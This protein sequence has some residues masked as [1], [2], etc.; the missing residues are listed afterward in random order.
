MPCTLAER[1]LL[2]EAPSPFPPV[3]AHDWV[4]GPEDA[5]VT[6]IE[7]GDFQCPHCG[8][9]APELIRLR[10]E[11][12]EDVRLV[13][14]HFPL[15]SLHDKANLAAQAAEAAGAQGKFWQMHDALFLQ[16]EAWVNLSEAEFKD[17]LVA[18]A[19]ALALD[20]Q[21]FTAD[22]VSQSTVDVVRQA[23][24]A[25]LATGLDSTPSLVIDG[26][27]YEGAKDWWTLA[28]F[29]RLIQLESRHF[30]ACPPQQTA[31]RKQYIATLE[32]TKG[33]LTLELLSRQ[34]PLAVNNFVFLA[35][36][37]WYDGVE[38]YRVIPGYVT[39]TGDPSGT[40]LGGPGYTFADEINPELR[41]AAPGVVAMANSGPDSNG[42]QFFITYSP[43]PSLDGSYTIFGKVIAGLDVLQ[44]LTKR[45]PAMDTLALPLADKIV[46]VTIEER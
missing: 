32:T 43:Q 19:Q 3:D 25:A 41:F 29:V 2:P 24:D 13:F 5:P 20:V 38:F 14:R 33:T 7:Y 39:Q 22:L 21:T 8:I 10:E 44:A 35:R 40:G 30:S 16:Q 36:Q 17:W 12:P 9:L 34:A 31:A 4:W 37:G 26:Q 45:D 6:L 1:G 46:R 42:S 27:Y 11:L 28:S 15:E 23:Y 18:Q